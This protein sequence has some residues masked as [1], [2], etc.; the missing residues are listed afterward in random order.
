MKLRILATLVLCLMLAFA[1]SFATA[2][3][4]EVAPDSAERWWGVLAAALCGTGIR[5]ATTNPVVGMNPYVLAATIGS[6]LLAALDL[7]T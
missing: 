2:D 6:C 3:G 5:L 4:D 7:A 1:P